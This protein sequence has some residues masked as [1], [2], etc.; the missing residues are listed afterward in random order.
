MHTIPAISAI[1]DASA[2]AREGSPPPIAATLPAIT[3]AKAEVGP[4]A[5]W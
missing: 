4:T 2:T 3:M 1:A 5:S